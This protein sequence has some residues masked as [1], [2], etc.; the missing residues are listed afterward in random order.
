MQTPLPAVQFSCKEARRMVVMNLRET[1]SDKTRANRRHR[2]ALNRKVRRFLLDPERFYDESFAAP[3]L[4][5]WD[6]C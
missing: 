3:S 6:L 1:I 5:S 4:S 2:R